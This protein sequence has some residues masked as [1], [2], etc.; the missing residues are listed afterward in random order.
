MQQTKS[1]V[2]VKLC[3]RLETGI[4]PNSLRSGYQN[5][6]YWSS[7]LWHVLCV[8]YCIQSW[9]LCTESRWSA[10]HS[11]KLRFLIPQMRPTIFCCLVLHFGDFHK[12]V[13]KDSFPLYFQIK[14]HILS[15]SSFF[16]S[17]L[18]WNIRQYPTSPLSRI[19]TTPFN[20]I[21]SWCL[22]LGSISISSRSLPK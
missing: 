6:V 18:T 2:F 9:N 16:A 20:A 15:S 10:L 12:R 13:W 3:W 17:F 7:H 1:L 14:N 22:F 8:S 21:A 11:Y 4:T 19:L 5:I